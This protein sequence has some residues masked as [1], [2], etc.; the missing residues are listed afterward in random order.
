MIQLQIVSGEKIR[1]L[2]VI[3]FCVLGSFSFIDAQDLP[4]D[5][6]S[7]GLNE[8]HIEHAGHSRRLLIT[9]PKSFESGTR[10][11]TL[12]CFHGAGGK[13]DGQSMR[14]GRHANSRRL[15]VVSC[16]AVQP[17]AKW[18]FK[19]Q[20]H[21]V[22]H[23][24]VGLVTDVI[25]ALVTAGISDSQMIYATGHSSG[26]L[27]CYRLAKQTNLFA[28]LAPMSCG[29]AKGD[30]TPDKGTRP[31]SILQVIG[32]KDKSFHGSSNEEVTMYSADGRI[33]IWQIFNQCDAR[34]T[35][36]RPF[37]TITVQTYCNSN[38]IE[39]A[40]V[41]VA[42]EGHHI[43]RDLR[44]KTDS[45]ALDFLMRHRGNPTHPSDK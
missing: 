14:W 35:I 12:F 22:D 6:L 45:I 42:G 36:N 33:Q 23:D 40:L 7:P 4:I 3:L 26:G 8:I 44:D 32:D 25:Q 17:M 18:N 15:L 31:V 1:I 11:A 21:G 16:E 37:D 2:L 28:A 43:R 39:V 24:D 19:D 30:H 20:F 5:S 13:A 29:M 34:P 10:Y 41:T 27:F 9:A 38:G